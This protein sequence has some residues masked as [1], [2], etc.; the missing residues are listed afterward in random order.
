MALQVTGP[1]LYS[2]THHPIPS[3]AVPRPCSGMPRGSEA[4]ADS[5]YYRVPCERMLMLHRRAGEWCRD[6]FPQGL[7]TFRIVS[8][9]RRASSRSIT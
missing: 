7:H 6:P 1:S 9:T 4:I 8:S 3:A 5:K 2:V